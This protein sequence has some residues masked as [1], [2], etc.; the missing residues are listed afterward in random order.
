MRQSCIEPRPEPHPGTQHGF[1]LLEV[2]IAFTIMAI[3]LVGLLQA[4]GRGMDAI[5]A[6]E[7]HT[8]LLAEAENR[9]AEVGATIPLQ[10]GLYAGQEN[11]LSWQVAVRTAEPTR[12]QAEAGLRLRLLEVEVVVAG[13]D[14]ASQQLRTLRLGEVQ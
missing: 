13:A 1:T 6:A 2:L 9:L 12:P 4:F 14:G 11:G 8:R 3:V 7:R 10:P 5:G